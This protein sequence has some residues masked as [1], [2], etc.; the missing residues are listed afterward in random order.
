MIAPYL[1]FIP[2]PTEKL[3]DPCSNPRLHNDTDVQQALSCMAKRFSIYIVANLGAAQPCGSSDPHCPGDGQYQYSANVVYDSNGTFIARYFKQNLY[4]HET[5]YFDKPQKV[6]YTVFNTSFGRFGTFSSYDVMFQEPAVILIQKE[7]INNIVSPTSWKDELP[8]LASIEFHSAFSMGMGIN[9]LVANLHIPKYG[10]HGSG[11][12]WPMGTSNDGV[13]YYNDTV[14]STGKLLVHEV[15]THA[16]SMDGA[17]TKRVL[18]DDTR[19]HLKNHKATL[20][21]S[22]NDD[23]IF[24]AVVNHDI[25]TMIPIRSSSGDT[26]VCQNELCCNTGFEGMNFENTLYAMGAFDGMHI[27][28][29]R[30]YLQACIFIHCANSSVASCGKPTENSTSY[31]SKMSFSGNFSTNYVFPEV[32]VADDNSLE[33]VTRTWLYQESI[34]IDVGV[35]GSPL[36]ISMY[37]RDYSR[38]PV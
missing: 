27:H 33:I 12:Y 6:D 38:D 20:A 23:E 28:G 2:D 17:K 1:E 16:Q 19:H 11:M 4:Q 35:P 37:A 30:Y 21:T 7:K 9:F 31:M 26:K 13:Y 25:Y 3:W 36:S 32:L 24:K 14:N 29:C 22:E 8:L 10:Y 34:I 18:T 15:G 5:P